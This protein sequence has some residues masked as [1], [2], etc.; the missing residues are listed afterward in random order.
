MLAHAECTTTD[1]IPQVGEKTLETMQQRAGV[2]RPG[3]KDHSGRRQ[4]FV[5]DEGRAE[6]DRIDTWRNWKFK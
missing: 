3:G 6:I 2:V 1:M 5:T 4:W